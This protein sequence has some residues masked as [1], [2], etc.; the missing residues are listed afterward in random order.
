MTTS[1][2]VCST[3]YG[4]SYRITSGSRVLVLTTSGA[5]RLTASHIESQTE[6]LEG[7]HARLVL[8]ALRHL[9]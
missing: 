7:T 6:N 1:Y 3:P 9:I 2:S 5:Q 8:N 4:I